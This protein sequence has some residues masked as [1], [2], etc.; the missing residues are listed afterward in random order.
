MY[1]ELCDL[2]PFQNGFGAAKYPDAAGGFHDGRAA[3][4]LMGSWDLEVGRRSSAAKQGF[5]T[6]NWVGSSFQRLKVARAKRTTSL[7]V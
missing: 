2:D 5:R 4:H 6:R 1:K 3:F 7:P